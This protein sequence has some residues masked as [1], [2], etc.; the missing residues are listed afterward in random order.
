M[1]DDSTVRPAN[2]DDAR[3][4]Q[5]VA[6]ESWHAAY[7]SIVGADAVDDRVDSW[8]EPGK[9]VTDDVERE[10]R[11]FFVAEVD[12]AVVGFVEAVPAKA[13]GTTA[14]L[15]RIYVAPDHWERGIG[16][17][18][19]ERVE[20]VLRDRGIERLELSVLAE[21]DVGVRF[22]ESAGFDRITSADDDEFDARRYEYA[23][24]L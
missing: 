20:A 2:E 13:D 11:P 9:L 7:D 10:S 1:P 16:R 24:Q 18:L 3:A 6:R 12:G 15:Y 19:L 23:K 22:Y 8:Y 5:Q 4:I 14:H 17:S 21:N